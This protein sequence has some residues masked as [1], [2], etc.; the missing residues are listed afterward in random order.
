[1]M[2]NKAFSREITSITACLF[3]KAKSIYKG[4]LYKFSLRSRVLNF[5]FSILA[6]GH[7]I[8]QTF[9]SRENR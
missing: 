7:L 8:S 6:P 9:F 5:A 1:M 2:N 4:P 3:R